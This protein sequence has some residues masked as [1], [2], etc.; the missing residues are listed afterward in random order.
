MR[1]ILLTALVVVLSAWG[2]AN[3]RAPIR[4]RNGLVLHY[5]L[6]QQG[7]LF[8]FN[9]VLNNNQ[10]DTLR[11]DARFRHGCLILDG[12]GDFVSCRHEASHAI[13]NSFT[14]SLWMNPLNLTQTFKHLFSKVN[15]TFTDNN[16]AVLFRYVGTDVQFYE[17]GNPVSSGVQAAGSNMTIPSAN[18]WHH[19]VYTYDGATLMGYLNGSRKV[20]LAKTFTLSSA[21]NSYLSLGGNYQFGNQFQG[22]LQ[23]CKLYNRALTSAEVIDMYTTEF[24]ELNQMR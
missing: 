1:L 16:Y 11:G 21:S 7:G 15:A 10:K 17:G 18:Q 3:R 8:T 22:R 12:T 5:P 20:N 14:I 23:E 24:K 13:T 9:S 4:H 2:A 6:K 19:V